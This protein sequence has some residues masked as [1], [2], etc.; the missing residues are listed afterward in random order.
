MNTTLSQKTIDIIQ[1]LVT[2]GKAFNIDVFIVDKTGIRAR[3][4]ESYIFLVQNENYDFL[5]FDS[6]CINRIP[7]LNN[8]L[9]FINNV[10]SKNGFT[11]EIADSKTL[12]SGDTVVRKLRLKTGTTS[13]EITG[14]NGAKY[15]LPSSVDDP[16]LV[17]FSMDNESVNV[18]HGFPRAVQHK[19]KAINIAGIGGIIAASTNDIE[20][21]YASHILCKSPAF[22]GESSDFSFTYN[23]TN[24]IPML[25][26]RTN[27][28]IVLTQRG[29]MLTVIEGITVIIFPEKLTNK[30]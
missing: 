3:A 13:V 18:L 27:V 4:S 2:V 15:K 30:G 22:S 9:A 14:D 1:R 7:E 26:G 17:R 12:D 19:N 21:D 16:E 5:E 10:S 24:L 6:L 20:G 29:I 28:D 23:I 11:M 8:R 25:R